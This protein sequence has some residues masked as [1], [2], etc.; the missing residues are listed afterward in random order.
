MSEYQ[1]LARLPTKA[2]SVASIN[3]ILTESRNTD[4]AKQ[5]VPCF[6]VVKKLKWLEPRSLVGMH[7]FSNGQS[8]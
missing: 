6:V 2:G 7:A 4:V 3:F 8:F 5:K 1:L